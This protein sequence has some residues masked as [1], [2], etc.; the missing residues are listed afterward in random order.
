MDKVCIHQTNQQLKREGIKKLGAFLQKSSTMVICYTSVYMHRLWTVYE[1]ACFIALHP[2]DSAE[3]MKVLNAA[4]P[5]IWLFMLC[6][7]YIASVLWVVTPIEMQVFAIGIISIG[8]VGVS[9]CL[10]IS[11]RQLSKTWDDIQSF[12]LADAKCFCEDDR[13]IIEHN[14]AAFMRRR[15]KV[16]SNASDEEA[17][18]AFNNLVRNEV[19]HALANSM[20]KLG[21]PYRY[22]CYGAFLTFI[23]P[24]IEVTYYWWFKNDLYAWMLLTRLLNDFIAMLCVIP[25]I[26]GLLSFLVS[27]YQQLHGWKEALYLACVGI[28]IIVPSLLAAWLTA[29]LEWFADPII[30]VEADH[31]NDL[32]RGG[33]GRPEIGVPLMLLYDAA[34]V[35]LTIYVY[36]LPQSTLLAMPLRVRKTL[37][38]VRRSSAR[39]KSIGR[40]TTVP[41]SDDSLAKGLDTEWKGIDTE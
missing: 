12:R 29:W 36:R 27:K 16:A 33:A 2:D 35:C 1:V 40:P 10:R 22:I 19:A 17:W 26:I 9:M 31:P 20:G 6:V 28:V 5:K 38:S 15:H 18:E 4:L 21:M 8:F 30:E 32:Y 39:P 24:H 34:F 3:Y 25:L 11:A 7:A 13:P 14:I 41:P 23:G 37:A